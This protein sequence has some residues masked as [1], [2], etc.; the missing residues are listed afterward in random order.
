MKIT[1]QW[2]TLLSLSLIILVF[3][4]YGMDENN[5]NFLKEPKKFHLKFYSTYDVKFSLNENIE[6]TNPE[7]KQQ[8][9][10]EIEQ[11]GNDIQYKLAILI[12]SNSNIIVAFKKD[13]P[14]AQLN[15]SLVLKDE[16]AV[17]ED[18]IDVL[19]KKNRSSLE[20]IQ[21]SKLKADYNEWIREIAE[22]LK[23]VLY[24]HKEVFCFMPNTYLISLN[25]KFYM[26][27]KII[28]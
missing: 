3:N 14:A 25:I 6:Q 5:S 7:L 13:T 1:C 18:R 9:L 23:D 20:E 10:K 24:R 12:G 22:K 21:Y 19:V 17:K 26:Q 16:K 8:L 27:K 4:S 2:L 11:I 28:N 15:I